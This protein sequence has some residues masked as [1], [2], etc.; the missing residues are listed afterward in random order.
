MLSKDGFY[1]IY[2]AFVYSFFETSV[3]SKNNSKRRFLPFQVPG[4]IPQIYQHEISVKKKREMSYYQKHML[5][6]ITKSWCLLHL[7]L[8]IIA[9]LVNKNSTHHLID[10]LL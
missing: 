9:K 7:A 6:V 1:Y 2:A 4:L 10:K 5:L 3:S 8:P